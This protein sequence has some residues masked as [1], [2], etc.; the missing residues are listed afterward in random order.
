MFFLQYLPRFS[1]K[2]F[3]NDSLLYN[4]YVKTS[5]VEYLHI[6]WKDAHPSSLAVSTSIFLSIIYLIISGVEYLHI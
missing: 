3:L 2:I 1:I 5:G 4:K 6:E